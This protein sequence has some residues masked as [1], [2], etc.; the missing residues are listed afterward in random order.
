MIFAVLGIV[1]L[2]LLFVHL[3]NR[4]ARHSA[5]PFK[6]YPNWV[7]WLWILFIAFMIFSAVLDLG[8]N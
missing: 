5:R 6:G 8:T 3:N 2:L 1:F 4:T 7:Y